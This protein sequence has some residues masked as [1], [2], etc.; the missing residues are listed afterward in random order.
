MKA[1]DAQPAIRIL[2]TNAPDAEVAARIGRALVD[3]RLAACVNV[4]APCVS[5]Y[6]WEGAVQQE[7]EVPMLIKTAEATVHRAIER[8]AQLHPY[9]VPEVLSVATREGWADYLRWV[10]AESTPD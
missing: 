3:E 6:R 5:L 4:L 7:Q 8:I 2:I 9:D 1:H 10:S